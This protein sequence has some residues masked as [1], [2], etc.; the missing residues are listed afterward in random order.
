MSAQGERVLLVGSGQPT[1]AI[2]ERLAT[3]G[4]A[5]E[6]FATDIPAEEL[7]SAGKEGG[8]PWALVIVP[9]A[10]YKGEGAWDAAWAAAPAAAVRHAFAQTKALVRQIMK[11]RRGRIA[12]VV[13]SC[14]LDGAGSD[15][16]WTVVSGAVAGMAR[17]IAR[18][19]AGR[20]VTVN[21]VAHGALDD[22]ANPLGRAVSA[23]G[24]AAAVAWLLGPDAES[25]TGQVLTVDAGRV[26]R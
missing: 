7:E 11:A 3:A 12:Y 16:G 20:S 9:P 18:E 1:D 19:L 26:M 8:E 2:A 14:G 5:V 4:Y 21:T 15:D 6:R 25:V 10:S 22:A 13:G 17:T 23:E 24:V